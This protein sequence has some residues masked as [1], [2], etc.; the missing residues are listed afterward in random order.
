MNGL[1]VCV[2]NGVLDQVYEV[3]ALPQAGFKTTARTF[4]ERR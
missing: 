3:D 1:I 4:R 2:G